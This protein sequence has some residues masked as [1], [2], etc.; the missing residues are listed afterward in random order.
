MTQ[1]EY[2]QLT[3]LASEAIAMYNNG[4]ITLPELVNDLTK[5]DLSDCKGLVDTQS[6][7]RLAA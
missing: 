4:L 1:S 7:L 6:G 2:D 3:E 5:L